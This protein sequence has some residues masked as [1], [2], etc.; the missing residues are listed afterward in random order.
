[1]T[2]PIIICPSCK[3]ENKLTESFAA[4]LYKLLAKILRYALLRRYCWKIITRDRGS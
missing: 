4:P 2:E 1:M 3:A